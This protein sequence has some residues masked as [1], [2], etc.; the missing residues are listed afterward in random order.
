MKV[1]WIAESRAVSG[2]GTCGPGEDYDFPP[3]VAESLIEQGKAIYLSEPK[4][5]VAVAPSATIPV[6]SVGLK[7]DKE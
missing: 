6:P 7:I 4:P 1:R 3:H 5:F 2:F